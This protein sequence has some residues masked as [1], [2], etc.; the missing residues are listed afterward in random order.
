MQVVFQCGICF[1]I[2]RICCT[3]NMTDVH[4]LQLHVYQYGKRIDMGSLC[5]TSHWTGYLLFC[6]DDKSDGMSYAWMS[7]VCVCVGVNDVYIF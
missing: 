7:V 4:C 2:S 5:F 6:D 1:L 3:S